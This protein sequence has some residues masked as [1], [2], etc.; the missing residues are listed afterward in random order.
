ML[1]KSLVLL[2]VSLAVARTARLPRNIP[3]EVRYEEITGK[4]LQQQE[5]ALQKENAPQQEGDLQEIGC[6]REEILQKAKGQQDGAPAQAIIATVTED[7]GSVRD[8]LAQET[9]KEEISSVQP[10]K[11]T[12]LPEQNAEILPASSPIKNLE[13][14]PQLSTKEQKEALKHLPAPEDRISL[15]QLGGSSSG[16]HSQLDELQN[17]I[18][19]AR[20]IV[21]SGLNRIK[22]FKPDKGQISLNL[23]QWAELEKAVDEYFDEQKTKLSLKQSTNTTSQNFFAN[24]ANGFQTIANN[25]V[26]S[27]QGAPG[28]SN[29]TSSDEAGGSGSSPGGWQGFVS[30]FQGGIQTISNSINNL[31]QSSTTS[32][33]VLGDSPSTESQGIFGNFVNNIQQGVQ[34]FIG[35]IQGSGQAPGG[36]QGDPG[37]NATSSNQGPI[38]TGIQQIGTA[39]SNFIQNNRPPGAPGDEA[40]G[41]NNTNF[42]QTIGQNIGNAIQQ[43]NPFRPGQ[44]GGQGGQQG[45]QGGLPQLPQ[46]PGTQ[47]QNPAEGIQQGI[48]NIGSQIQQLTPGQQQQ[49]STEASKTPESSAKPDAIAENQQQQAQQSQAQQQNEATEPK[50]AA[51]GGLSPPVVGENSGKQETLVT[52]E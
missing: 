50:P 17:V 12:N 9:L 2:S 40:T 21:S 18:K 36:T 45:A 16:S 4:D 26:Q 25:F 41:G 27:I 52:V 10:E 20:D 44:Q 1:I 38:Q 48:Q 13:E 42:V 19:Q 5:S 28:A 30:F 39:I 11:T 15:K 7:L 8:S 35:Q 34:T 32:N 22:D 6:G 33:T 29:S 23:Q 43:F 51:R 14:K 24:L 47:G 31:G 46:I 3:V 37:T 49:P